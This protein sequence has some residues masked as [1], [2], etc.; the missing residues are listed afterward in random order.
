MFHFLQAVRVIFKCLGLKKRLSCPCSPNDLGRREGDYHLSV[1]LPDYQTVPVGIQSSPWRPLQP[2]FESPQL[3]VES[4]V[5]L[6][7]VKCNK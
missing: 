7:C 3:Q 6:R 5:T 2:S 1:L 4:N